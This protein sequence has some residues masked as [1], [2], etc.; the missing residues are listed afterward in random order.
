MFTSQFRLSSDHLKPVFVKFAFWQLFIF[1]ISVSQISAQDT[2]T[3]KT[4]KFVE[5]GAVEV[6]GQ[7]NPSV[8]NNL[9]RK[10]T[11]INRDE[12]VQSYTGRAMDNRRYSGYYFRYAI[13]NLS[14]VSISSQIG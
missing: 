14:V 1:I 10:I 2:D 8:Y 6:F 5:P 4:N 12:I 13:A 9:A 11:V 7:R 3:I